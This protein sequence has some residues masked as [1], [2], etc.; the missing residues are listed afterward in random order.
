M[1][2]PIIYLVPESLRDS[3]GLPLEISG[4]SPEPERVT[5]YLP[6]TEITMYMALQP[7]RRT[8]TSVATSTGRLLPYLFTLIPKKIGTVIFCYTTIPFQISSR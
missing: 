7:M 3:S 6:E 2:V 5:L 4:Y 8:A 1:E